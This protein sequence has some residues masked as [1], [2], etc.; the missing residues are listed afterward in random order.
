M[1][2]YKDN[3]AYALQVYNMTG[4][5]LSGKAGHCPGSE[6]NCAPQHQS[7]WWCPETLHKPSSFTNS[8]ISSP[9]W[10]V[11]CSPAMS[12]AV[13]VPLDFIASLRSVAFHSLDGS[14]LEGGR[15]A[16]LLPWGSSPSQNHPSLIS[17]SSPFP[18]LWA[19]QRPLDVCM[20]SEH[21]MPSPGLGEVLNL[22]SAWKT[23]AVWTSCPVG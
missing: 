21:P 16:S 19:R 3:T 12:H 14:G 4:L 10:N 13:T 1:C 18:P 9:A 6:A 22:N 23:Q 8:Y 20:W 17:P 2:M 15:E 11:Y 7:L 5:E